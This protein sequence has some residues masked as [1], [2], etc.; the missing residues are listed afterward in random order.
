MLKYVESMIHIS[1][2]IFDS[3]EITFNAFSDLVRSSWV[4]NIISD[5]EAT[6]TMLGLDDIDYCNFNEGIIV[7]KSDSEILSE[8]NNL[9]FSASLLAEIKRIRQGA[10]ISDSYGHPCTIL[11]RQM[12]RNSSQILQNSFYPHFMPTTA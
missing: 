8:A 6:M 12:M 7:E 11:F 5:Y 3:E 1:Y 10:K 4:E 9:M 2:A